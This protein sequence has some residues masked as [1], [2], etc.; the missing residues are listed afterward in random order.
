LIE[1]C[2]LNAEIIILPG[3]NTGNFKTTEALFTE[4]CLNLRKSVDFSVKSN[5]VSQVMKLVTYSSFFPMKLQWLLTSRE[6]FAQ[7]FLR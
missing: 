4:S 7:L 3:R 2:H 1:F 5:T 6:G